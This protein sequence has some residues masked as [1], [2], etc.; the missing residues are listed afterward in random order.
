MVP[1][2]IH[3]I[4]SGPGQFFVSFNS[5]ALILDIISYYPFGVI[6]NV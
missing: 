2:I 3:I 4:H 6:V 1:A 5:N